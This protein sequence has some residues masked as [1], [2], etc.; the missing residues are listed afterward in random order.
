MTLLCKIL[1]HKYDKYTENR[2]EKED[3]IIVK[4]KYKVKDC[5][6]CE[7]QR[8]NKIKTEVRDNETNVEIEKNES[9]NSDTGT[10]KDSNRDRNKRVSKVMDSE[11]DTG[12]MLQS[13]T[14]NETYDIDN[15]NKNNKNKYDINCSN[16]D[17]SETTSNSSRRSGDLCQ[18]CGSVIE[19]S[20]IIS[21]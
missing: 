6:R 17:Y 2:E 13:N 11:E 18:R 19:V 15:E 7:T 12:V 14:E 1:G 20:Q 3:N 9:Y 21:E 4:S 8:E 5:E 10:E 16:C